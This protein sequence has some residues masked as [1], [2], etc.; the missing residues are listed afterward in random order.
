MCW[1][2]H[3]SLTVTSVLKSQLILHSQSSVT[4]AS[5]R[6]QAPWRTENTGSIADTKI[7]G[8]MSTY[9]RQ[10]I[11]NKAM[12]IKMA[13]LEPGWHWVNPD[14]C[15]TGMCAQHSL[16]CLIFPPQKLLPADPITKQPSSQEVRCIVLACCRRKAKWWFRATTG[17]K[18]QREKNCDALWC[19]CRNAKMP[20]LLLPS[21]L[22]SFTPP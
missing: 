16:G 4:G 11:W 22:A 6:K 3:E 1:I 17:T 10:P 18:P 5:Q 13:R 7:E 12:S 14:M 8:I 9:P 20:D 2:W 19:I 21:F 15:F